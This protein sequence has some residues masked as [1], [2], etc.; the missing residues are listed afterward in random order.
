MTSF[1]P[2]EMLTLQNAWFYTVKAVRSKHVVIMEVNGAIFASKVS[3]GSIWNYIKNTN[4][5]KSVLLLI[6]DISKP[7]ITT[8]APSTYYSLYG[9]KI[10]FCVFFYKK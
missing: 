1:L 7:L 9:K 6:F 10:I 2:N 4:A 8:K 3:R 5:I